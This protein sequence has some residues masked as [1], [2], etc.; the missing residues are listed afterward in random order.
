MQY[1]TEFTG[2]TPRKNRHHRRRTR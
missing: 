2:L 1:E